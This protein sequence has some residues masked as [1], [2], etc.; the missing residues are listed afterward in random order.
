MARPHPRTACLLSLLALGA[1]APRAG[2]VPAFAD[3]VREAGAPPLASI[4]GMA[5]HEGSLFLAEGSRIYRSRDSGNRW[6][7]CPTVGLGL[8]ENGSLSV[9]AFGT[10]LWLLAGRAY[11]LYSDDAGA[12]WR[13][14]NPVT[15]RAGIGGIL[16]HGESLIAW[17]G[18]GGSRLGP[19]SSDWTEWEPK[20]GGTIESII[21]SGGWIYA[22]MTMD[23]GMR[24]V[25]RLRE[26]EGTWLPFDAGFP[27]LSPWPDKSTLPRIEFTDHE[28]TLFALGRSDRYGMYALLPGAT[29]WIKVHGD[30]PHRGA[31]ATE[32]FRTADGPAYFAMDSLVRYDPPSAG[33]LTRAFTAPGRGLVVSANAMGR[34]WLAIRDGILIQSS[35]R[36]MHW[37]P[38]EME[39]PPPQ[40]DAEP[41][42]S[43]L[44]WNGQMN[45]LYK[46]SHHQSDNGGASW[47]TLRYA[48]RGADTI[49]SLWAGPAPMQFATR[50]RLAVFQR[51]PNLAFFQERGSR[52]WTFG[53]IRDTLNDTWAM[54]ADADRFVRVKYTSGYNVVEASRDPV[55]SWSRIPGPESKA[56][57]RAGRIQVEGEALLMMREAGYP[58]G[59]AA[60]LDDGRTWRVLPD[61]APARLAAGCLHW[62]DGTALHS[63]CGK[64]QRE[65]VSRTPF[66]RTQAIFS[67]AQGILF[68]LADSALYASVTPEGARAWHLL[69]DKAGLREWHWEES[70]IYRHRNGKVE[71][72]DPEKP[73]S[74]STRDGRK[75]KAS[76]RAL[77][78]W[79]DGAGFARDARGR[80]QSPQNP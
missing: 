16:K 6:E 49:T 20:G 33:W 75:A 72:F 5:S 62:I 73:A 63:V 64:E 27:T 31:D 42:V 48:T 55:V 40:V 29:Q 39:T 11:L 68:A 35:N 74:A 2:T 76:P 18:Y 9:A 12:S 4:R 60:T 56:L 80:R 21:S 65:T 51:G 19:G 69:A 70:T 37:G 38:A 59:V 26:A 46:K 50:E 3:Y 13:T 57:A 32:F 34:A 41:L 23:D 58:F 54:G 25:Q 77:P 52:Q 24:H 30:F 28:G 79:A 17:G 67:N 71:W 14:R 44:D 78:A 10:R 22:S 66:P 53:G 7:A 1:A 61:S 43:V 45:F 8:R 15:P 47:R 36:G